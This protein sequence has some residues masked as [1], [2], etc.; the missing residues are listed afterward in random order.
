M[1]AANSFMSTPFI[2]FTAGRSRSYWLSHFLTYRKYRCWHDKILEMRT[3]DELRDFLSTPNIGMSDS[4]AALMI[5]P[6]LLRT[7]PTAKRVVVRR[8]VDDIVESYT[9]LDGGHPKLRTYVEGLQLLLDLISSMHDTLTINF[10][11]LDEEEVCRSI[12]EH[13]LSYPFDRGH[14]LA[15]RDQNLTVDIIEYAKYIR[16]NSYRIASFLREA[17]WPLQ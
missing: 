11:D 12:F 1:S 14:W 8:P 16:A 13:C 5:V 9:M 2:I 6:L 17:Q 15:L 7:W 4:G 3:A 10:D